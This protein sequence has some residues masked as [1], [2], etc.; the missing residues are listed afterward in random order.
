M[1]VHPVL[2]HTNPVFAGAIIWEDGTTVQPILPSNAVSTVVFVIDERGRTNGSVST[3]GWQI[4]YG[5]G[6]TIATNPWNRTITV[7]IPNLK[8]YEQFGAAAFLTNTT[9]GATYGTREHATGRVAYDYMAFANSASNAAQVALFLPQAVGSGDFK[10]KI[11]WTTTNAI[12]LQTNVWG[13]AATWIDHD[14]AVDGTF[15]TEVKLTQHVVA[16]ND[17]LVTA[18]GTV[19]PSGSVSDTSM[20]WLRIRRLTDDANDVMSGEARLV[21]VW[22][23]FDLAGGSLT[24]F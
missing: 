24:P 23:E 11:A 9:D 4:N 8:H 13:V 16:A 17:L 22:L 1:R 5:F 19:T 7:P 21:R 15:G 20:M 12:A 14:D 3:V 2:G 6:L 10:V 18:S